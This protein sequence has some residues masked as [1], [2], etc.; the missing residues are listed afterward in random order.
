M[1]HVVVG[2]VD[3]SLVECSYEENADHDPC[4]DRAYAPLQVGEVSLGGVNH[5]G[6]ANEGYATYFRSDYGSADCG[7]RQGPSSE[8]EVLHAGLLATHEVTNPSCQ[9]QVA[10]HHRPVQRREI[11]PQI[12]PL[13]L[14]PTQVHGNWQI[15]SSF[16][17]ASCDL[18]TRAFPYS[19]FGLIEPCFLV[20]SRSLRFRA[21]EATRAGVRQVQARSSAVESVIFRPVQVSKR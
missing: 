3:L 14:S 18:I 4:D 1:P 7:P 9:Q 12:H 5:S 21:S 2:A 6:N 11:V 20:L 8:E 17:F 10:C 19:S 15:S 13:G 16:G